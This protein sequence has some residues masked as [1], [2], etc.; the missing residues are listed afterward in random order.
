VSGP[1]REDAVADESRRFALR[2][3]KITMDPL[4]LERFESDLRRVAREYLYSPQLREHVAADLQ[5]QIESFLTT[6]GAEAAT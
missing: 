2:A 5:D 1:G 6:V 4:I 3:R